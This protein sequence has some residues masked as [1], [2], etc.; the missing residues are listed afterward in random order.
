MKKSN[1]PAAIA[2]ALFILNACTSQPIEEKKAIDPDDLAD[3]L[4]EYISRLTWFGQRADWSHDGSR[5]LFLAKTFGDAYEVDVK[6]SI[7]T[8]VTHHYYHE[9]YVRALYLANGDILLS[10]A[11][12][13]DA[14]DPLPSRNS[15]A[16][17]WVLDKSL[18]KPPV[19]LN[20]KC[21]EGP[22]VSRTKMR[23]AWRIDDGDYPD[24]LEEGTC[25]LWM[26]DIQYNEGIP[27]MVN[28]KLILDTR[29]LQFTCYP[30]PQNFRPP[31]EKELIFSA[32]EYQGTEVMGLDLESGEITNYSNTLT[33]YDE[34][35]GIFPDGQ[36]TLVE[37][38]LH[39]PPDKETGWRNIDIY[40]LAL[41]G[42][43]K[44][45][46]MTYFND[47]PDGKASNP[48]VSD[49]GKYMAF[50]LANTADMAGVGYG[51][52]IYDLE[53]ASED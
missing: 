30:E 36:F 7:I 23:I 16:E 20:M 49:D 3:N 8:P 48:V 38:D 9:G 11:P 19:R 53:K 52:F 32:Y 45:E 42:S 33:Q 25:Q 40:K 14:E 47:F 24:K 35:E 12:S 18:K 4:P 41:D 29:N 26:A 44:S 43:G 17:L 34:P 27:E 21:S 37:A 50:Q 10:G 1:L 15:E 6:T 2:L 5:I 46:R 51:I 39:K 22:A 28:S 31:Q 13:F